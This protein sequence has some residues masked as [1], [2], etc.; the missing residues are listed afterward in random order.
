M[1]CNAI[2]QGYNPEN[3]IM[4]LS[5]SSPESYSV[6]ALNLNADRILTKT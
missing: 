5:N 1:D 2:G 6:V 4:K 3:Q